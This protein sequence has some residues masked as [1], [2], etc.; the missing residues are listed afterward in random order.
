MN[1][2]ELKKLALEVSSS[3]DL[4]AAEEARSEAELVEQETQ[5]VWLE[6]QS[7]RGAA[8]SA[9]ASARSL[10]ARLQDRKAAAEALARLTAT[11]DLLSVVLGQRAASEDEAK[12]LQR[13]ALMLREPGIRLRAGTGSF[14]LTHL[15]KAV[16]GLYREIEKESGSEIELDQA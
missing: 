11:P 7:A 3:I 4:A 10:V 2:S 12:A 16:A 5:R 9:A 14:V 13:R 15:A 8:V 6:A 1:P